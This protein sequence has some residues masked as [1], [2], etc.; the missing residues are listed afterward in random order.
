MRQQRSDIF[1]DEQSVD[2]WLISYADFMTLLFAFFVVMYS[3]S[4]LNENKYKI[5]SESLTKAFDTPQTSSQPIQIGEV[6]QGLANQQTS[7]E[8]LSNEP[9][10]TL[11][12]TNFASKEEFSKLQ[13]GLRKSLKDLIKQGVA[14]ITSDEDWI[15]INLRSGLLFP[16]GSDELNVNATPLLE[17]VVGHLNSNTQ[18]IM[19]HGHTDNIPINTPRFPSNWELS[20]ARAVAVVRNLQRL[21]VNPPRMSVK[22]HGEYQPVAP[23]DTAENR[24]KNRRVVISISRKQSVKPVSNNTQEQA[25]SNVDNQTQSSVQQAASQPQKDAEPEFEIVRLPGGG[26]LIRGKDLPADNSNNQ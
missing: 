10:E 12:E 2:R 15:N 20:S 16:V 21:S 25:I 23:N 13:D 9:E 19:V 5:L 26:I 14:E 1:N 6:S 11:E 8:E 17:E 24:A 4:Q 7:S 3:I 22:G 18:L